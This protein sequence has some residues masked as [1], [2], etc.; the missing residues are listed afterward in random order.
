MEPTRRAFSRILTGSLAYRRPAAAARRVEQ[1]L[2]R[3]VPRMLACVG[4]ERGHLLKAREY[5][6]NEDCFAE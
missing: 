3:P 1:R 5:E 4:P 6:G 2:V